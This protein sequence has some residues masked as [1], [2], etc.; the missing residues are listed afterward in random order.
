MTTAA[1][2]AAQDHSGMDHSMHGLPP[3]AE[4]AKAEEP[5]VDHSKMDHAAMGHTIPAAAK[6]D[7]TPP[8]RALVG[9][10]HAADAIWGAEAMQ[11]SRDALARENGAMATHVVMVER[12][13]AR[14]GS[15]ADSYAWDAQGWYGGDLDKLWFKTEGGGE[16]G[17]AID[18]A[19]VQ[20]LWSHAIAPFF[21]LQA[22]ARLDFKPDTRSHLVL[23]IQGLA[24]Y[25]W[26]VDAAAFLS[27]HG[28]L[29]GRFKAEYDQKLTQRLIVQPRAEL[30]FSTSNIPEREIG[31]GLTSLDAGLRLRY[32]ISREFAPYIGAEYSAKLGKTAEIARAARN[33][34]TDMKILVGIRFW[35]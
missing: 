33:D 22:G 3:A 10:L 27:D 17:G 25:M 18:D 29:T 11:P 16:F 14:L 28:D 31:A 20:A 21:D 8:D 12:F 2:L 15:G 32:E 4:P 34:P 23:G 26:H 1:P 13:E 24:P 19:E 9:P 35:F 5:P 7:E 30:E 6:G